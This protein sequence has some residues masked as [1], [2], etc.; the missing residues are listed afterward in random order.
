MCQLSRSMFLRVCLVC[1]LVLLFGLLPGNNPS[2]KVRELEPLRLSFLGSSAE[3]LACEQ[4]APSPPPKAKKGKRRGGRPPALQESEHRP[5]AKRTYY[6]NDHRW[7]AIIKS[8]VRRPNGEVI[9]PELRLGYMA[10]VSFPTPFGDGPVHGANSVYVVEQG[11]D[12]E[13]LIIRT[14]KWITMHHNCGWGHDGKFDENL[15]NPQPLETI[16]F[17]I[18]IDKLWDQNFHLSVASGDMLGITALS[19]GKPVAG[20][21][22]TLSSEKGWSKRVVTDKDGRATIQMIRDYY[23]SLW[24]KFKRTHRGEFLVTAHYSA[25][26]KGSFRGDVYTR[27]SYITTLPWQYSPSLNDYASYSYGLA[28]ALLAMTVSGFGVY[29]YRERRRKPYKGISFDE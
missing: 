19:Y 8:Y 17:E 27:V 29:I 2:A 23:P 9:E 25:D 11:V 18:V 3:G 22:V 16:P 6:F 26:Q 13:V 7:R 10:N 12:D 15:I 21:M 1:L 4:H 24:S 14:A 5:V 28:L 20:A